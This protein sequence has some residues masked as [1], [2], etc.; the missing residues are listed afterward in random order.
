MKKNEDRAGVDFLDFLFTVAISVGLTPEILQISG[1]AGLLSEPWSLQGTRFSS[2]DAFNCGVFFLGLFNLTLSWFG[3][4]AS[5][6]TR[7]LNYKSGFGMAR[8]MIDVFLVLMF[9]V[10][11]IKHK[12]FDVVLALLVVIYLLYVVWDA[13][14]IGE[15]WNSEFKE[16]KGNYLERFRREWVTVFAFVTVALIA[17]FYF[18][19]QM[20]RRY[21]LALAI[22][23]TVFYRFNKIYSTWERLLGVK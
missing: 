6:D 17:V 12:S 22:A 21:A 10:L 16:K 7:P 11:L 9:G 13:L 14:K 23:I 19:F 20:D 3:Y 5:L 8:F 4:H 1:V 2:D 18:Y 15:Y